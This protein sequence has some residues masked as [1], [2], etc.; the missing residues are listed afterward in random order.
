MQTVYSVG[1]LSNA[2]QGKRL[3]E[4]HGVR[5]YIRR[6]EAD[7]QNGCGYALLVLHDSPDVM[8]MLKASSIPVLKT[9]GRD[10]P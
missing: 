3:L 6:L 9:Q 8:R 4:K 10:G 7:A 2:M 1:S 5:A